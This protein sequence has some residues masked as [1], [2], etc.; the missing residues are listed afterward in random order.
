[1]VRSEKKRTILFE[2]FLWFVPRRNE[3]FCLFQKKNRSKKLCCSERFFRNEPFCLFQ[4]KNRSKKR[5]S[6]LVL[7]FN[8]TRFCFRKEER[9]GVLLFNKKPGFV[10]LF[11]ENKVLFVCFK[12]KKGLFQKKNCLFQE[13]KNSKKRRPGFVFLFQEWFVSRTRRKEDLVFVSFK[14][15]GVLFFKK[16]NGSFLKNRS[17][18]NR[19]LCLSK[20]KNRCSFLSGS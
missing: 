1:M 19:C 14:K 8:K 3:P 16:K 17:E 18:K 11:Q 15:T 6:F 20:K 13:P 7:L 9:T 10:F 5:S 12:N 4:K 2:R